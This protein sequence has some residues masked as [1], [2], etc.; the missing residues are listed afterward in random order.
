MDHS[1][2]SPAFWITHQPSLSIPPHHLHLYRW[3]RTQLSPSCP[4]NSLCLDDLIQHSLPCWQSSNVYLYSDLLLELRLLGSSGYFTF[5]IGYLTD[6]FNFTHPNKWTLNFPP[7]LICTGAIHMS[8]NQLLHWGA[9][10]ENVSSSLTPL[11]LSY[12]IHI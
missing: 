8:A 5:P 11:F 6:S 9:L 7:S 1:L 4:I 12:S 10:A 3:G 2:P